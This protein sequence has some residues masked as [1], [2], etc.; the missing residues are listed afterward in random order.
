[1]SARAI[2]DA[3]SKVM[4]VL[5]ESRKERLNRVRGG[6]GNAAQFSTERMVESYVDLYRSVLGM[7]AKSRPGTKDAALMR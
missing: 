3:S 4:G 6:L 5:L 2:D 1:M 7:E